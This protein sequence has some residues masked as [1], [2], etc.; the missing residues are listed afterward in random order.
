MNGKKVDAITDELRKIARKNGGVL[1]PE[2][3]L[4]HAENKKSVLHS[5]FEWDDTE[6]ARRY[7]IEQ[8]RELIRV[9][10]VIIE[11]DSAPVRA[12]VSIIDD[13]LEGKPGGYRETETLIKTKDGREAILK[14]A[15]WELKAFQK[16]YSN[17]KELF[18]VFQEIN[19]L[20]D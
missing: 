13:R 7:R 15:L 3:V 20:T 19:K 4:A 5:C 11:N 9:S 12:F 1:T 8:A 17:L 10:V 2:E 6:A 18:G 14:T 16:K